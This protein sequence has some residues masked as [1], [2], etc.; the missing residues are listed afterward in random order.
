MHR[1]WMED[2]EWKALPIQVR[3]C[4]AEAVSYIVSRYLE[5]ENPFSRDYLLSYGNTAEELIANL[6][7]VQAA[8]QWMIERVEEI[9]QDA[10][11]R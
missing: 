1:Q 3:E 4:Q 5:I 11:R 9:G 10:K 6:G 2:E 7:Q 8:S